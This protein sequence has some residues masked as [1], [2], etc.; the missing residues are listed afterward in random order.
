[1]C[2]V[3]SSIHR[4]TINCN[5]VRIRRIYVLSG[6]QLE[7]DQITRLIFTISNHFDIKCNYIGTAVFKYFIRYCS[8]WIFHYN[9]SF[10]F[11]AK[12]SPA[13]YT[14]YIIIDKKY[15]L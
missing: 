3:F 12:W 9:V 8:I 7:H 14:D 1:M 4:Y 5:I 6:S 2:D 13:I 15:I 11:N 10:W